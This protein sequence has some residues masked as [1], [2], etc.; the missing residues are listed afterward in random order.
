M[1]LFFNEGYSNSQKT[2]ASKP[3]AYNNKTFGKKNEQPR[4]CEEVG[5]HLIIS[6]WRLLMN[7]KNKYLL[8]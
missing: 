3:R 7:L 1:K 5:A 2:H 8:Q 4:T 6:F